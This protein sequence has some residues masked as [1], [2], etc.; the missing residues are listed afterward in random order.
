MVC[1][2]AFEKAQTN[3]KLLK[4]ALKSASKI[5]KKKKLEKP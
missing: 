2:T 5:K 4:N 1:K 3:Q